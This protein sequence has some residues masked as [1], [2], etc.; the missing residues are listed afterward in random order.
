MYIFI[1]GWMYRWD[2]QLGGA[3]GVSEVGGC[4]NNYKYTYKLDPFNVRIGVPHGVRVG[5]VRGT[6]PYNVI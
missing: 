4:P 3:V 6:A 2:Y 5:G 1:Y